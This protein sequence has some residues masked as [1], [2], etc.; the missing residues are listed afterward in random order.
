MCLRAQKEFLMAE[1]VEAVYEKGMLRLDRPLQ[2]VPEHA[3]VK[4]TVEQARVP[5][6]PLIDC[7]GILPDEDAAEMSRAIEAEFEQVNAR[8]W[9]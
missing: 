6:H 8:E 9:E 2:E 1:T 4:V 5:R 7:I 3:R